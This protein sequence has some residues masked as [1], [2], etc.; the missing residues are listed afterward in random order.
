MFS[1]TW[2]IVTNLKQNHNNTELSEGI[3][4]PITSLHCHD[5]TNNNQALES[6]RSTE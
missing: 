2:T 6:E 3:Q 5:L 1:V 4:Q